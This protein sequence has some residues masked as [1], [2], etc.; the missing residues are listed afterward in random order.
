VT[1]PIQQSLA[2]PVIV[3]ADYNIDIT[4]NYAAGASYKLQVTIDT[5][6]SKITLAPDPGSTKSGTGTVTYS[7]WYSPVGGLGSG[8]AVLLTTSQSA[9]APGKYYKFGSWSG[10]TAGATAKTSPMGIIMNAVSPNPGNRS[11]TETSVLM[12]YTVTTVA[13]PLAGGTVTRTPDSSKGYTYGCT[14]VNLNASANPTYTFS[15][16]GGSGSA[17]HTTD[18]PLVLANVSANMVDT[19]YFSFPLSVNMVLGWNLVSVPSA[20]TNYAADIV[21][22]HKLADMYAYSGGAYVPVA[23]LAP[24]PGYWAYYTDPTTEVVTGTVA[25][26]LRTSMATGWNLVGSREV[27]VLKTALTTIP[28]GLILADIYR[29]SGGAYVVA[30][31]INPGEGVWVYVTG[32]CV[33]TIP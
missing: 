4:A 25:L 15:R 26:P 33:L 19:A 5:L 30:N 16:W 7:A 28:Y 22:P 10:D 21:F 23:T 24:G 17:G 20:Q 6:R 18:M 13:S 9:W 1:S 14:T 31:E 3:E 27:T 8:D 12:T 29:Y 11:I 2:N 32:P